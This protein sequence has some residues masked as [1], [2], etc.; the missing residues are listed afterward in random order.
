MM[1]NSL[2]KFPISAFHKRKKTSR[3]QGALVISNNLFQI[4]KLLFN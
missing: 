4:A 1:K 3:A 2:L